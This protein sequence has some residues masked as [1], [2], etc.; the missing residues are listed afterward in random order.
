[1]VFPE[2]EMA[3]R[4][5]DRYSHRDVLDQIPLG[6]GVTILELI[7]PSFL[8]GKSILDAKLRKD[9]LLN[10]IGIKELQPDGGHIFVL[11]R[12]DFILKRTDVLVL[13]GPDDRVEAFKGIPS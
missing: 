13:V 9:Y 1:M 3:I 10:V 4:T 6:D 5:A 7:V 12:P 8:V 11:A 2:K